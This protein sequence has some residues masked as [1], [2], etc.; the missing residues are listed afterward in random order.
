MNKE[1]VGAQRRGAC[2]REKVPASGRSATMGLYECQGAE[3]SSPL[4]RVCGASFSWKNLGGLPKAAHFTEVKE[5]DYRGWDRRR[6]DSIRMLRHKVW[7]FTLVILGF[8]GL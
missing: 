2:V 5:E 1:R 6:P 4:T 3:S 7:Y 8:V